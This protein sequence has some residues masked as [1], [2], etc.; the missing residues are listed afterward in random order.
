MK[1]TIILAAML[2]LPTFAG[3]KVIVNQAPVAPVAAPAVA[4]PWSVEGAF[5]YNWALSKIAKDGDCKKKLKNVMGGDIT[6]VYALDENQAVTL[7]FGYTWAGRKNAAGVYGHEKVR[8]HTFYLMPGYRYT[9]PIATDWSFFAGVNVGVAN[10]STKDTDYWD[11]TVAGER[12]R[13]KESYHK[14]AWGFAY[15]IEAGVRYA[16]TESVDVFGAWDFNGNTASCKLPHGGKTKA[17]INTGFRVG[18]GVK[19]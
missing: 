19:F 6:G 1:K 16:I 2:A 4:S 3:Q 5:T 9:C 14:A 12:Y 10:A 8:Q 13:S 15:S 18:V 7:R 17:Q 11:Y